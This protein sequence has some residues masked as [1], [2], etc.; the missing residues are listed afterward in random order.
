MLRNRRK[1]QEK[2]SLD[3]NI[4]IYTYLKCVKPP[5]EKDITRNNGKKKLK[6]NRRPLWQGDVLV[7][8]IASQGEIRKLSLGIL[9]TKDD[10][11]LKNILYEIILPWQKNGLSY[12]ACSLHFFSLCSEKASWAAKGYQKEHLQLTWWTA[13]LQEWSLWKPTTKASLNAVK[14]RLLQAM[15]ILPKSCQMGLQSTSFQVLAWFEV[16]PHFHLLQDNPN[17]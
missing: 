12:S 9:K 1:I 2:T 16:C 7:W 3:K 6:L 15:E 5:R 17:L 4:I 10:L 14:Q 13:R 8:K 11:T